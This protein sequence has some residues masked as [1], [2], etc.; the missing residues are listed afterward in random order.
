MTGSMTLN[1]SS[2]TMCLP[3]DAQARIELESTLASD[4]LGSTGLTS[5]GDGWQTE[6]FDTAASRI[7]LSITST[8]SSLTARASGGLSMSQYPG[9]Q[10]PGGQ[11]PGGQPPS[12]PY[13]GRP[14]DP[15]APPQPSDPYLGQPPASD[16]YYG[17][18]Q[19]PYAQQAA[20]QAWQQQQAAQQ[21]AQQQAWWQAQQ[22]PQPRRR[23]ARAVA[24]VPPWR[25]SSSSS[26]GPGSSSATQISVDLG[27]TWPVIAVAL[28]VIMVIAA[29]I[30]RRS[31]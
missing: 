8:V 12:D 2:L 6:G 1:A 29:F 21:Q 7:D 4:D 19:D 5:V 11:Y 15:Y 20:Y 25:A 22:P 18:P 27:Q 30:P 3:A 9:G 24:R 23:P 10:Y 14:P 17:Q 28:G 31:S 13:Y 26:S 16:P